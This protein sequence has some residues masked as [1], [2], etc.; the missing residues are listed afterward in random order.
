MPPTF[1]AGLLCSVKPL[2]KQC[3]RQVS[4]E[5]LWTQS[6]WQWRSVVMVAFETCSLPHPLSAVCAHFFFFFCF[7]SKLTPHN[8]KAL[9][10][11]AAT[12]A[13]FKHIFP[14]ESNIGGSQEAPF[15]PLQHLSICFQ[16]LVQSLRGSTSITSSA[17]VCTP[18]PSS[19]LRTFRLYETFL[20]WYEWCFRWFFLP[21]KRTTELPDTA[22]YEETPYFIHQWVSDSLRSLQCRLK[23]SNS[24]VVFYVYTL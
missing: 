14:I 6:N 13:A 20:P 7:K 11:W 1:R 24:H 9:Y 16:D 12:H 4:P 21:Q 22:L 19:L 18:G 15:F 5:W 10:N 23:G 2:W 17:F 8:L 3:L